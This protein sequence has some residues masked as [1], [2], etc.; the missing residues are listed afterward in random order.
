LLRWAE[1][2]CPIATAA[3]TAQ[4]RRPDHALAR[5][6]RDDA[7]RP[8][9]VQAIA[10]DIHRMCASR[11]EAIGSARAR[12]PTEA[13]AR[14]SPSARRNAKMATPPRMGW[15]TMNHRS[16]APQGSAV[17]NSIAETFIQPD[18]GSAANGTPASVCGSHA[19]TRPAARLS[20]RKQWWGRK[21]G[22]T[23]G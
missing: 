11:D 12:P 13:A 7:A 21:Y 22:S 5:N 18:C 3:A 14:E 16:A 17:Y 6:I 2:T 8:T 4:A 10:W 9:A 23:S 20:P 19:G 1:A 15:S